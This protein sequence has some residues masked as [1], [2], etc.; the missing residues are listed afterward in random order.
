[1]RKQRKRL[2]WMGW[3][4]TEKSTG[5]KTGSARKPLGRRQHRCQENDTDADTKLPGVKFNLRNASFLVF[6]FLF[7][8]GNEWSEARRNFKHPSHPFSPKWVQGYPLDTP[9]RVTKSGKR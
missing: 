8:Q 6:F 4:T 3:G 7:K 9:C 2:G 1:M 5:G